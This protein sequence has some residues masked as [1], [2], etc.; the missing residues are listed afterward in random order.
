MLFLV[1]SGLAKAQTCLGVY[2]GRQ[3]QILR[4]DLA[5]VVQTLFSSAPNTWVKTGIRI[6]ITK[7]SR[8]YQRG[9]SGWV[10]ENGTLVNS[11]A[12]EAIELLSGAPSSVEHYASTFDKRSQRQKN[13]KVWTSDFA[14]PM[15]IFGRTKSFWRRSFDFNGK[16]V[17]EKGNTIDTVEEIAFITPQFDKFW[18]D[19]QIISKM[20]RW[21]KDYI[22]LRESYTK[23]GFVV[24]SNESPGSLF[25]LELIELINFVTKNELI[26][27]ET[28][29]RAQRIRHFSVRCSA[30]APH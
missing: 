30:K 29:N 14:S 26:E 22:L 15:A 4:P 3:H 6:P 9:M 18:Q 12:G 25:Y 5:G 8:L 20:L 13:S 27:L 28:S 21:G 10:S 7:G 2:T 1:S 23:A 19:D 16:L 11:G 17:F 24:D